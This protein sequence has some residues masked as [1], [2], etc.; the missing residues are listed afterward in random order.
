M[1]LGAVSIS[2]TVKGIHKPMKFYETL[3]FGF[4][5]GRLEQN[6]LIMKAMKPLSLYFKACSRTIERPSMPFGIR[7]LKMRP[8]LIVFEAFKQRLNP[9]E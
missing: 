1:K 3:G 5:L 6:W 9:W 4:L 2:L 8:A 7:A